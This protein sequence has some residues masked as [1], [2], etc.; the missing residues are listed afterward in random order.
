MLP[1]L[2]YIVGLSQVGTLVNWFFS[3]LSGARVA[4][5]D[6]EPADAGPPGHGAAGP[7]VRQACRRRNVVEAASTRPEH[8][9]L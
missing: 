3:F 9:T 5:H 6:H 4:A 2:L 7:R 1:D 8:L